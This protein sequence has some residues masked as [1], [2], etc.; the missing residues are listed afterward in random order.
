MNLNFT[1]NNH[2][3][4]LDC[5]SKKSAKLPFDNNFSVYCK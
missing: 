1:K 2:K 5:F 4:K 3:I